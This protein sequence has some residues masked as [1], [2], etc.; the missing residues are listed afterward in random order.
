MGPFG[1]KYHGYFGK[2][3]T[4]TND[5]SQTYSAYCRKIYASVGKKKHYCSNTMNLLYFDPKFLRKFC[6]GSKLISKYCIRAFVSGINVML[7]KV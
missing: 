2:F 7:Q 3:L 4:I 6:G 1:P 5:I